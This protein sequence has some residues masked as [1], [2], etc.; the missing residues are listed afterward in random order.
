MPLLLTFVKILQCFPF[1][2]HCTGKYMY[3]H[4]KRLP[5]LPYKVNDLAMLEALPTG[6]FMSHCPFLSC[7]HIQSQPIHKLTLALNFLSPFSWLGTY[8][9]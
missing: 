1:Q 9:E 8:R 2:S 3:S 6:K 5:L 7:T 4:L